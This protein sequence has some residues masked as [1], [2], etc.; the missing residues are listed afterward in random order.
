MQR[1]GQSHP[2]FVPRGLYRPNACAAATHAETPRRRYF[3]LN[4]PCTRRRSNNQS[5]IPAIA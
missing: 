5:R 1:M 3:F 4:A 2:F